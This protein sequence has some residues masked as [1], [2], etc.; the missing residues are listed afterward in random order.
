MYSF[1]LG[2]G[3]VVVVV[4]FI[5]ADDACGVDTQDKLSGNL[6]QQKWTKEIHCSTWE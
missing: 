6:I 4:G 5:C 2:S 3:K 1:A